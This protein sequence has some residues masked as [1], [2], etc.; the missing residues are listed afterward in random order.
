MFTVAKA[1]WN[2]SC[3]NA[4]TIPEAVVGLEGNVAQSQHSMVFQLCVPGSSIAK[5]D[6]GIKGVNVQSVISSHVV[7]QISDKKPGGAN[8]Q[9]NATL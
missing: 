7:P 6:F 5:L 9:R 4:W 8:D 2:L 3:Q 1:C